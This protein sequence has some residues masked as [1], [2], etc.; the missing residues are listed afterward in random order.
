MPW[1]FKK[2]QGSRIESLAI[3]T[4]K[5]VGTNDDDDVTD[6]Y[7]PALIQNITPEAPED[8]V[9]TNISFETDEIKEPIGSIEKLSDFIEAHIPDGEAKCPIRNLY[10]T[11]NKSDDE[12]ARN[13]KEFVN[14][15]FS[16]PEKWDVTDT[17]ING[18]EM[19]W[20]DKNL[21]PEWLQSQ[22]NLRSFGLND[23]RIS[24]EKLGLILNVLADIVINYDREYYFNFKQN[25]DLP[26]L[27]TKNENDSYDAQEIL[28]EFLGKLPP[29]RQINLTCDPQILK[30]WTRDSNDPA[31]V[32]LEYLVPT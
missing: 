7:L 16:R 21:I 10:I 12:K 14:K 6:Q 31:K 22:R 23:C 18:F 11:L 26:Y 30:S 13:A 28:C 29:E 8:A 27:A 24:A 4:F 2:L 3:H 32:T 5:I 9:C 15:I 20:T 17:T 1:V 25:K 19:S